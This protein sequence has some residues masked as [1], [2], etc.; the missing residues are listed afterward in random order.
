MCCIDGLSGW[1]D[2]VVHTMVLLLDGRSEND[3]HMCIKLVI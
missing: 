2:D 1:S 3:V